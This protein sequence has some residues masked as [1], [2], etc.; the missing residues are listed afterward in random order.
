MEMLNIPGHI[1]NASF[2]SEWNQEHNNKCWQG[3]GGKGTFIQCCW[4]CKL[5]QQLCK[6]L[7]RLF[8]KLKLEQPYNPLIPFLGIYLKECKSDYNKDTCIPLFITALFTIAKIW[9]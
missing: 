5:V 1:G 8:R 3:C 6:T 4:K 7:W 2:L 9:K